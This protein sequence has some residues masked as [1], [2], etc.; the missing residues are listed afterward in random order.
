VFALRTRRYRLVYLG[1]EQG[2]EL[3]DHKTDPDELT[4]V[5]YDSAYGDVRTE[6]LER[7]VSHIGRFN[8]TANAI[9][10][11]K[12][13]EHLNKQITPKI[14]RFGHLWSEFEDIK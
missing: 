13:Q 10:E 3:Y 1:S 11:R 7:M 9:E 14:H 12:L 5:Y 4:N 6:L 8:Y 2:A